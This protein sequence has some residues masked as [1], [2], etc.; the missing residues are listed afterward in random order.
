MNVSEKHALIVRNS[1]EVIG[2]EK[3]SSILVQ[4]KPVVYCG[5]EPSG[6]VHLGHLVTISKLLD[7]QKAGFHVKVLLADWHG[8]L[9]RKGDWNFIGEQVKL[10]K[11]KFQAAGLHD[12]EF[13]IG[14]SFQRSPGYIDDVMHLAL[15]TTMNRA[16]RSMVMVAR[17]I[18]NAHVSQ[19]IYP[20]MQIVDIKHLGV[21]VVTAGIE[22]RKIHMLGVELFDAIQYKTPV[23]VHT[24][25]ISS[26]QGPGSK[27]S[28][29][30]P[31]SMIS[32]A[33]SDD[34]IMQK[35]KKAYCPEGIK[36][37]NPILGIVR[38]IIFSRISSFDI[39]RPEKFGGN[40][41]FQTYVALEDAFLA[42]QIHPLDLK[43]ATAG[44]L[45]E[46][47]SQIRKNL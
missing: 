27:M 22:Q 11:K 29:S 28:S 9:N 46:I 43:N 25:L 26:L 41:S 21:D 35:I 32:I 33:D 2:E 14:S 38:L 47:I 45:C 7:F 23:F 13:I 18:E 19:V 17:D 30:H 44:Y 15:K 39:K 40:V 5:Y 8:W 37:D 24:P 1:A 4:E 20:L 36:E 42:K 10:W 6:E 34:T 12:A 16:L 31:D 3:L